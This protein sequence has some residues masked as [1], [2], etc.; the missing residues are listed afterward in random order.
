S[1]ATFKNAV[2][3]ATSSGLISRFFGCGTVTSSALFRATRCRRRAAA[4]ADRSAARAYTMRRRGNELAGS[5]E[6]CDLAPRCPTRV[7]GVELRQEP[8]LLQKGDVIEIC[9]FRLEYGLYRPEKTPTK[10]GERIWQLRKGR[11]LLRC[12]LRNQ[13]NVEDGVMVQLFDE[14]GL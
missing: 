12:E 3:S 1:F 5:H 6:I 7:N 13:P 10:P 14:G 8:R 11:R 4:K 2:A 9:V